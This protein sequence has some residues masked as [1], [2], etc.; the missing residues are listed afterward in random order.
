MSD[1]I[2]LHTLPGTY[3]IR[4]AGAVLGESNAVIELNEGDYPAVLYVPRNDLAM[5]FFDRSGH[6]TTCPHKGE[7][8]Y[9]TLQAKSGPIKDAAW[10]YETPVEGMERIAGHLAFYSDKVTVEEI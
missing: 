4:A 8:S 1:H 5:D 3:S 9:Y 6:T 10:S 7:A 2:K